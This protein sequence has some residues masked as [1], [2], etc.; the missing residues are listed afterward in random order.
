[1]TITNAAS[2]G[3]NAV[4]LSV[5][6]VTFR[7]SGLADG[8]QRTIDVGLAMLPGSVNTISATVHG[9]PGST[10]RIMIAN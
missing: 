8:E 5:N 10:A 4:T 7:M 2:G 1:V 3:V 9:A 6:G